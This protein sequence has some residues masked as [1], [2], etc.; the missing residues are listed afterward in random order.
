[1]G[2]PP[3]TLFNGPE[4]ALLGQAARQ[5]RLNVNE[6]TLLLYDAALGHRPDWLPAM[7]GK[8]NLLRRLGRNAEATRLMQRAAA[9]DPLAA[10]FLSARGRNALLPY[11]ALYP[12]SEVG[13]PLEENGITSNFNET[14][15]FTQQIRGI[16]NLPDSVG[17]N[18]VLK[19]KVAGDRM[20]SIQ[21]L[22][23]LM[24][25]HVIPEDL[26]F[27][28]EGNLDMLNHD[29][30][31]AIAAY[32][33]ALDFHLTPW[34]EISYNRGLAFILVDNYTNGCAELRYAA[35]QGFEPAERMLG[36]LCNF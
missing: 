36:S 5:M 32:N 14:D 29:Y 25:D 34:P 12:M 2:A 4:I 28:L 31:G 15:Y 8:A 9:Q 20:A 27:M 10:G 26:G 24:Q 33:Q 30:L 18:R 21:E 7:V 13:V 22:H 3:S 23:G 16:L 6:E 11:V 1:V 35:R 17:L 19:A